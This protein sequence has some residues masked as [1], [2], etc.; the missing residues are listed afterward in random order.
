MISIEQIRYFLEIVRRGSLNKASEHL[1]ISQ[2]SLSKQLR[3]LEKGLDCKLLIRNYS[4]VE[5]TPQGRLLYETMSS[6]MDE[7]DRA[8]EQVRYSSKIQQLRIGGL[9]NLVTYF[10]PRYMERLRAKGKNQVIID[11]CLSNQEL[12]EGVENGKFD[13]VLLSNAEPQKDVAVIPLMTEPLYVVFPVKHPL[14]H[15]KKVS[16]LDVVLQEKL[17]LYKDPCTIRASIRKACSRIKVIPNVALELDLT[18]SLLSYVSRGKGVT[19]LPSIVAK[20]IKT[21]Y[22]AVREINQ[23]P[24]YR[25]I[26]VAMKKENIAAYLPMFSDNAETF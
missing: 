5:T 21:P 14:Y 8:V 16:F 13:M 24:I 25:E 20:A 4:G 2:P 26:A 12:V 1:Y 3:Q 6:V 22:I 17:V 23:I 15:R 19:I 9:G 18:E 10:L 7:F 11:T